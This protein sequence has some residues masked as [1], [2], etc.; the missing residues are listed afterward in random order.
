[1]KVLDPADSSNIAARYT[2]IFAALPLRTPKEW[3][4]VIEVTPDLPNPESTEICDWH[5]VPVF[6]TDAAV[7]FELGDAGTSSGVTHTLRQAMPATVAAGEPLLVSFSSVLSAVAENAEEMEVQTGNT[8]VDGASTVDGVT[9]T[10]PGGTLTGSFVHKKQ[11]FR[12][13][14][15]N[16]VL[17]GHA[18]VDTVGPGDQITLEHEG[19]GDV[20]FTD[21]R[22]E[23]VQGPNNERFAD[24]SYL[25]WPF[26][27]FDHFGIVRDLVDLVTAAGVIPDFDHLQRDVENYPG[28]EVEGLH[29]IEDE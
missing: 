10:F 2:A 9:I 24:D 12:A 14:D 1:M 27:L 26:Y 15:V 29:I 18:L 3:S 22:W 13:Y 8:G 11:T 6:P 17:I 20:A 25:M 16:D 4:S 23:V 7:A 21:A 28:D 5:L 19:L